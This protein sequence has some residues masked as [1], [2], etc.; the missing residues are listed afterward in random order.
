MSVRIEG[1]RVR[2]A[3]GATFDA[4]RRVLRALDTGSILVLLLEPLDGAPMYNNVVGVERDGSVSW[5][6][7]EV[8]MG[9]DDREAF[10]EL[11]LRE[12][13]EL[14]AYHGSGLMRVLDPTTGAVLR[15]FVAK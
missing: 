11:S 6:I 8:Q 3:S 4:G 12:N 9:D 13:G 14:Y 10:G 15:S 2:L 1:K 5:Q 7:E